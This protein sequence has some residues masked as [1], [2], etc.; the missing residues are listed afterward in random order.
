MKEALKT[1]EKS[2]AAEIK[3][4]KTSQAEIRNF[5]TEMQNWLDIITARMEQAEEWIEWIGYI[6]R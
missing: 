3:D 6:E 4:L 5:I 1:Q 2:L